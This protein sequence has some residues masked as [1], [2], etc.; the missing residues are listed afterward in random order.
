VALPRTALGPGLRVGRLG[1]GC[2]SMTGAYGAADRAEAVATVRRALDLGVDLL[3]TAD[4]YGLGANEE[5]L[6]EAVG[7]RRSEVVIAT[8]FGLIRAGGRLAGVDGSPGYARRAC[9]ASLRRL[10]VEAIDLYTLHRVDPRVPIEDTVGALARLVEEGKVRYLGLSEAG[11]ATLRRACAVHPI[12]ALQSEYSLWTRDPEAGALAACRELGVGFVAYSPLGRGFLAAPL[13]SEAELA[14]DDGRRRHPRF[15]GENLPRNRELALRLEALGR[16][17]GASAAQVALAWVLAR[18]D[19]VVPI[20]GSARRRHLEENVAA[21]GLALGPEATAR[22]ERA[23]PP[24]AAAG[25]R[26]PPE[27]MQTLDR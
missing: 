13:E 17:L 26:Y 5:L 21:L 18:G 25:D 4:V 6:R 11:P 1:L 16:E 3:D 15:R 7:G 10:G 14:E 20:P 9:E 12:A 23:F 2:M 8:K 27:V 22:L 24:G 19:D